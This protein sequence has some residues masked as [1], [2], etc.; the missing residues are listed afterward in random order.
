MGYGLDLRSHVWNLHSCLARIGGEASLDLRTFEMEVRARN[1]YYRLYPR[2]LHRQGERV[3]YGDR[4]TRGLK[5]FAGW[6]PYANKRW[7]VG[8]GKF[9]FKDFCSEHGLAT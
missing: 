5:L 4:P 7:P 1:R 2:F 8:S 9:A 3:G 6:L